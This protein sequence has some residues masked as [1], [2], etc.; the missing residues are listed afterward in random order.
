MPFVSR[1]GATLAAL[2]LFVAGCRDPCNTA[3]AD[4][5]DVGGGLEPSGEARSYEV[6][7]ASGDWVSVTLRWRLGVEAKDVD[8]SVEVLD[9]RGDCRLLV[10]PFGSGARTASL[11]GVGIHLR[12]VVRSRSSQPVAFTLQAT[13][14]REIADCIAGEI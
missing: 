13:S 11:S 2:G 14:G 4:L 12:V 9:C 6:C 1:I 10:R 7:Q 8:M 5:L 3:L